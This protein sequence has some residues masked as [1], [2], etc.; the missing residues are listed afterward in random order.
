LYLSLILRNKRSLQIYKIT[1]ILQPHSQIP[2]V[3]LCSTNYCQIG[4][5]AQPRLTIPSRLIRLSSRLHNNAINNNSC[6]NGYSN[7]TVTRNR[8]FELPSYP[9]VGR[10]SFK[11]RSKSS[12]R[13]YLLTPTPS[14]RCKVI[15]LELS[16]KRA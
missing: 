7:Y 14:L 10:K 4:L 9:C 11:G 5:R 13:E 12:S 2:I 6:K 15:S 3:Q 1:S 16:S 8:A